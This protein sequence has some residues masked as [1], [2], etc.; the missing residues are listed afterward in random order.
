MQK[1]EIN[2]IINNLQQLKM[3]ILNIINTSESND[4]LSMRLITQSGKDPENTEIYQTI[5]FMNSSLET[6]YKTFKTKAVKLIDSVIQEKQESLRL[7]KQIAEEVE[8]LKQS[9][10]KLIRVPFLGKIKLK[11]IFVYI[12]ITFLI[13]FNS[14]QLNSN[15]A[16]DAI[17]VMSG[18]KT[19]ELSIDAKEK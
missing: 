13:L 18:N 4:E 1:E 5:I 16:M 2:K 3:E 17:N 14:F 8:N 15:A 12:L 9:N 6:S 11:D 19:I 7:M 10:G